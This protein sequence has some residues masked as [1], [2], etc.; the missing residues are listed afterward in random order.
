MNNIKHWISALRPRTLF[1]ALASTICGNSIAYSTGFFNVSVCVLSILTATFLQL[2]SN[3]ANDL[4]DFQHGTD[5]T[6]ERVGPTRTVQSGAISSTQMIRAIWF[7]MILCAISG[8]LLIEEVSRFISIGYLLLFVFLGGTAIV[9]AIKYTA[10]KNPYGYRGLGDL[11]AF[12]FFGPVAV[13][14][15]Y[16]LHV[17]EI[18]FQP[19]LPAIGI[20]LFT[21][22]VLNINN[23]R[24]M[25][26][27]IKSGK[28]T[29]AA[30]LGLT[31]AKL[32]HS[33]LTFGGILCF[34]WYSLL[35]NMYYYEYFYMLFF[36]PL[37][38]ILFKLYKTPS[39]EM[40]DPYLRYTSI[41]T[42][43]LSISFSLCITGS[44]I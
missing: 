9:A 5:V 27:D 37:I 7:V 4:G 13:V 10:G 14:G 2:L 18:S 44:Y 8:F 24:D 21:T 19:W 39:N 25:S 43:L 22:A 15:I 31:K 35:Y 41:S 42:F 11:F 12:V 28:I 1:L 26:N 20:G 34:I 32:Y 17:H 23:M 40:Y 6:G 38:W 16:F 30:K 3:L 29:L 33:F 36:F